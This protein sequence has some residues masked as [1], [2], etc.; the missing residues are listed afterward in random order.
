MITGYAGVTIGVANL[1]EA[2]R[3]V[4]DFGLPLKHADETQAMFELDDGSTVTLKAESDPSL[5]VPFGESASVREIVW[6]VDSQEALDALENDLRR[7]FDL[8]KDGDG[9]IRFTDPNGIATGLRVFSRK[10]VRNAPEQLN[11]PDAIARLGK[12]RRWRKRA[13]P[14]VIQH[15]VFCVD[16]SL[17]AARFYLH[18]LKFRLSDISK[19][20]GYFLRGNGCTEHHTIFFLQKG[21][22]PDADK[23]KPHHISFGV[24]DIDEMM[25]GANYMDRRGWKRAMG[26]GRHRIGSALFYYFHTPLG[27]EFEYGTDNDHLDPLWQ[28]FEWEP[29]FGMLTWIAGELPPFWR[30]APE[31]NVGYVPDN[32]PVYTP[33]AVVPKAVS[34]SQSAHGG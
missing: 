14:K 17:A 12:H 33:A 23:A 25:V 31:W 16:D 7:D 29:R 1:D 28:P 3:F 6:G 11:A 21:A 10:T 30:E 32:H 13:R 34:R 5:P 22:V 9:T 8:H 20:L 15:I 26:P 27:V 24:E 18:R 2:K 19:G 4:E